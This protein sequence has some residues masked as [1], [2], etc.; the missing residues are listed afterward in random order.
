MA[1]VQ[2][3]PDILKLKAALFS[4]ISGEV[5][6]AGVLEP[7]SSGGRLFNDHPLERG[8]IASNLS[9]LVMKESVD[10][11]VASSS[12]SRRVLKPIFNFT[13]WSHHEALSNRAIFLV[14]NF[15]HGFVPDMG[16]GQCFAGSY[17][18]SSGGIVFDP[19]SKLF[20]AP[21]SWV[22]VLNT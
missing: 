20:T 13:A 12:P 16:A 5:G 19:D 22:F 7:N 17:A 8:Q 3:T 6:F 18:L 1:I 21:L 9:R 10:L 4:G 2:V 11:H 15:L 14:R